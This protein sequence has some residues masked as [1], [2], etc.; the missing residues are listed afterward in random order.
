VTGFEVYQTYVALKLHF[1][2][3]SNFDY[4]KNP[5][6]KAT[7]T[8]YEKRRDRVWFEKIAKNFNRKELVHLF[9]ACI[10]EKN[11]PAWVGDL[12][13]D[14]AETSYTEWKKRIESLTYF[15]EQDLKTIKELLEEKNKTFKD[16][17]EKPKNELHPI[18]MLYYHKYI[19]IETLIILDSLLRFADRFDEELK[20]DLLWEEVSFMMRKYKPFI[21][22]DYSKI[23]K[24]IGSTFLDNKRKE[25][26]SGSSG[27]S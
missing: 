10:V 2:K 15:F 13:L 14:E 11:E 27:Q 12:L 9:V 25:T 19:R 22:V 6:V 3:G 5:K 4:L 26:T 7:K 1:T 17:F 23:V 8:T 21:P 20:D 18:L 16:L 24:T